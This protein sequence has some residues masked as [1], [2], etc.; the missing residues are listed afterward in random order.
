MSN[1]I[2]KFNSNHQVDELTRGSAERIKLPLRMLQSA[3]ETQMPTKMAEADRFAPDAGID[4]FPDTLSL[5]RM[6]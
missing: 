5:I 3:R 2:L 6:I 4:I 1:K